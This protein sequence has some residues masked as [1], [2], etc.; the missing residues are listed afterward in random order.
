MAFFD[1][2]CMS[3]AARVIASFFSHH[4]FVANKSS[5]LGTGAATLTTVP[6]TSANRPVVTATLL[7]NYEPGPLCTRPWSLV[8]GPLRL[9]NGTWSVATIAGKTSTKRKAP[10]KQD[11]SKTISIPQICEGKSPRHLTLTVSGTS[12]I[13]SS[14]GI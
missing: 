8:R 2:P 7:M 10:I 1:K 4:S 12:D 11:L 5:A 3:Y 13:P 9:F 6:P 14:F